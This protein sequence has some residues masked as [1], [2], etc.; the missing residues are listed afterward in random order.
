MI[1]P[2]FIFSTN[3]FDNN[4][5]A[6]LPGMS[7]VVIIISTSLA[8]FKNKANSASKYSFPISLA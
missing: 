1:D 7:A 8:Y 5:G 4:L 3:S 6:G 2:Y